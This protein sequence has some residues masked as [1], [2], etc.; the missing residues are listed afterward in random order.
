[1]GQNCSFWRTEIMHASGRTREAFRQTMTDLEKNTI[2]IDQR[3]GL[4]RMRVYP[5]IVQ[6]FRSRELAEANAQDLA[7]SRIPPWTVI[8]RERENA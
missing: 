1:M 4:W 2:V 6:M 7:C 8:I 3:D 5:D